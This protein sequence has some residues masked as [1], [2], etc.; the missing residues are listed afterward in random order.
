[1]SNIHDLFLFILS[2]F[3]LNLIPGPDLIFV[4]TRNISYGLKYGLIASLGVYCGTFVHVLAATFGL[5][6][7]IATS[8]TA[9][10]VIKY[11]GAFYLFYLAITLFY[12]T[13]KITKINKGFQLSSVTLK[14]TFI[15]AFLTNALNPKVAMFFLAFMPQFIHGSEENNVIAFLILGNIFNLNSIILLFIFCIA[16]HKIKT[17]FSTNSKIINI[18][19]AFAAGLFT[20]FGLRLIFTHSVL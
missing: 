12:D 17:S 19:K 8:A 10:T 18:I 3:L 16:S 11:I 2:G 7:I 5:S 14:K 1:M 20:F 13:S 15:Q 9:F 4:L 6:T